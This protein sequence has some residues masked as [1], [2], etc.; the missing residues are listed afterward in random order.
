MTPTPNKT[1]KPNDPPTSGGE[2]E[3]TPSPRP[4]KGSGGKQSKEFPVDETDNG[5]SIAPGDTGEGP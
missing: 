1:D 4:A 5:P 2:D 3:S